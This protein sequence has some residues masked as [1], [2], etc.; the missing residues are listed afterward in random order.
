M[1]KSLFTIAIL[2]YCL[3]GLY[4]YIK[5]RS[6][7]YFPSP[8]IDNDLEETVF[9]IGHQK[10]KV[11]ILNNGNSDEAII[12]FGGNAEH[13]DYNA[14]S[15]TRL[16]PE[17]TVYLVK[18]RGYSGSTG[19]PS[20]EAIYSD[21]SYIYKSLAK[22]HSHISV[23]G[24]SLG[25]AVAT[26]TAAKHTV[27]KLALITPFDSIQSVAQSRYPIYP[28]SLLLKDKHDSYSRVKSI[29]ADTLIIAAEQDRVIKSIHTEKLR[30]GFSSGLR[31]EIIKGVGHNDLASNPRYDE[32]LESFFQR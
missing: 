31:F 6:F 8:I 18:Y 5:Q 29:S 3:A 30:S 23:I 20:E 27:K 24:R 14:D 1:I 17:Y 10:I 21:A 28:M 15:F 4:L 19:E 32:V 25:S 11:S 12:Y 9:D 7:L 16:F 2:V 13:V 22:S 26:Y